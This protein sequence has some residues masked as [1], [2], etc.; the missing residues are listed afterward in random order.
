MRVPAVVV[1]MSVGNPAAARSRST[2]AA[3]AGS[4]LPRSIVQVLAV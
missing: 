1:A 3:T 2:A 4:T